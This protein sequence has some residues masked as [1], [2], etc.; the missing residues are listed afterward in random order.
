MVN[1]VWTELSTV[2]R[3]QLKPFG[4]TGHMLPFYSEKVQLLEDM[5]RRTAVMSESN[6]VLIIGPRGSG[7]SAILENVVDK[8]FQTKLIKDNLLYVALDG[9]VHTNDNLA[10]EDITRQLRMQDVEEKSLGSFSEKLRLLL[11]ALKSG[12]KESKSILFVLDNFDLFCSHKNQTLLYN[13]FDVAQSQQSPICVIGMACRPNVLQVLENRVSSRFSHQKIMLFEEMT[14]SEYLDSAKHFLTLHKF[15]ASKFQKKWN[16]DINSIFKQEEVKKILENNFFSRSNSLRN[17]KK[18]LFLV[19]LKIGDDHPK[20]TLDDFQEASH[21]FSED[22]KCAVIQGL[23]ILELSLVIAMMHLTE[24]YD[25]EPFNFEIVYNELSKYFKKKMA[26]NID[27]SVVIKAFEHLIDL[28]LVKP[29]SEITSNVLKRFMLVRLLV[30]TNE[31]KDA[32][33]VY[34]NLPLHLKQWSESSL[35]C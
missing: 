5:I 12:S 27:K 4:Y 16:T 25:G 34:Q 2:L 33:E 3:H 19:T 23:S 26:W 20:L 13:L 8:A 15:N 11:S 31:V 22:T 17:L 28:E 30:D 7:K 14:F 21:H 32:I 6:S 9:L 18:F 1:K 29:C 35:D 24:I 10:L